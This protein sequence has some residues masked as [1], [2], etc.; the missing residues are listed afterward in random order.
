[1]GHD[2]LRQGRA[3]SG[4]LLRAEQHQKNLVLVKGDG[5]RRWEGDQVVQRAFAE[6][7]FGRAQAWEGIRWGRETLGF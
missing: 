2:P 7:G 4:R 3:D 1:M 5:P 6:V